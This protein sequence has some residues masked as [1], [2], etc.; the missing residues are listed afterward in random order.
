MGLTT[1]VVN[2]GKVCNYHEQLM[3]SKSKPVLFV[4]IK[5]I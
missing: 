4:F 5:N 3:L 2:I 1:D